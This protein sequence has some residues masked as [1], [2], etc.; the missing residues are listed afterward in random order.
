MIKVSKTSAGEYV[1]IPTPEAGAS[2]WFWQLRS[3]HGKVLL[4]SQ[5]FLSEEEATQAAK[6]D[7]LRRRVV[8]TDA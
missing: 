1:V 4:T 5:R 2:T 8:D 6:E 3:K 7:S